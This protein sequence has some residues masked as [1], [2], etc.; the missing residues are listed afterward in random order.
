MALIFCFSLKKRIKILFL[1]ESVLC[2]K[3]KVYPKQ[4]SLKAINTK[5]GA[6]EKG[7]GKLAKLGRVKYVIGWWCADECLTASS[8]RRGSE[9]LFMTFAYFLIFMV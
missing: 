4:I 7:A 5:K 1:N 6:Q 2:T 3:L 9:P 8:L